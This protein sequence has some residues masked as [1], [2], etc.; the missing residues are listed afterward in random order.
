MSKFRSSQLIFSQ[1][2]AAESVLYIRKGSVKFTVVNSSGREAVVAMFGPRDFFG[3]GCMGG[4]SIRLGTAVAVSPTTILAIDKDEMLRVLHGKHQLSEHFIWHMI[5]R[6]IRI[7]EQLVAQLCDSSERLL[8][9]T[10]LKLAGYGKRMRP[11]SA[12]LKVSQGTLAKMIGTTRPRVNFFMNKFRK[13]GYLTYNS[14]ITVH[15]SLLAVV[16]GD[17]AME[18]SVAA[19]LPPPLLST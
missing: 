18:S 13:L 7:E 6:K 12:A 3:E 17:P 4:Q 8:A 15:K 19:A 11:S 14:K 9:R 2:D 5:A 1:G 16:L 10:L